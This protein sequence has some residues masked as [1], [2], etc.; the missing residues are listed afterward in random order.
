M[1]AGDGGPALLFER[2]SGA[3]M[4]VVGGVLG[5]RER[6]VAGLGVE[7]DGI[8]TRILNALAAPIAPRE[9]ADAPCHEIVVETPDLSQLPIPWFFEFETGRM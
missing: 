7:V 2:V 8:Q 9:I 3:N 6:I 4:P 5:T 1:A